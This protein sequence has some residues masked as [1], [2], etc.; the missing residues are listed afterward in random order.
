MIL[1]NRIKFFLPFFLCSCVFAQ[2]GDIIPLS[3]KVGTVLDAEE[4]LFYKVYDIEG[5]ESAQFYEISLR[6]VIARITIVEY[7]QQKLSKRK[8]SM[9]EF[10]RMKEAVDVQPF[11]TDED[12]RLVKENLTY[13]ETKNI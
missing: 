12:R 8:Y 11:I 3:Q 1:S 7:S 9:M 2:N 10:L 13:L 6:T 4:N 5:F